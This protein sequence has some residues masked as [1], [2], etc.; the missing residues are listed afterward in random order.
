MQAADDE[1]AFSCSCCESPLPVDKWTTDDEQARSS[2]DSSRTSGDS[3]ADW[4]QQQ[5]VDNKQAA[6]SSDF[7]HP[8]LTPHPQ[9]TQ[10]AAVSNCD[11]TVVGSSM[12]PT[13]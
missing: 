10:P 5:V 4:Y 11:T 1:R 6:V 3:T 13:L 8:R 12:L 9:H 2:S 7:R